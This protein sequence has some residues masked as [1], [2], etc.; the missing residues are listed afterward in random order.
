MS[1]ICYLLD[2]VD[3]R[4]SLWSVSGQTVSHC[5]ALQCHC[6][7]IS[8]LLYPTVAPSQLCQSS[9]PVQAQLWVQLNPDSQNAEEKMSIPYMYGPEVGKMKH[10]QTCK[11]RINSKPPRKKKKKHFDP[12]VINYKFLSFE[13]SSSL[14]KSNYELISC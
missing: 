11:H 2:L 5:Q 9:Q 3:Y 4:V 13:M 6:V 1:E 8:V 14:I 12:R 10:C 7:A